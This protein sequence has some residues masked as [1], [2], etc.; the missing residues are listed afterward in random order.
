MT[1]PMH[2]LRKQVMGS[3]PLVS[4]MTSRS[5][6]RWRGVSHEVNEL[7]KTPD[8]FHRC[9]LGGEQIVAVDHKAGPLGS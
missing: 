9:G 5:V 7:P 1:R 4:D 8:A 3:S 6:I 2:P